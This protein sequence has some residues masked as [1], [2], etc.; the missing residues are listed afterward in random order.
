[1]KNIGDEVVFKENGIYKTGRKKC[2][3]KLP[4]SW[5]RLNGKDFLQP[6]K[7]EFLPIS[8]VLKTEGK[9]LDGVCAK[10]KNYSNPFVEIMM[11]R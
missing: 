5:K 10:G 4:F 1:M 6:W 7:K 2:W 9:G 11:N 8:S 3:I